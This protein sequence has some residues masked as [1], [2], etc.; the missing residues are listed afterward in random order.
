MS[1]EH[2][3]YLEG[4]KI[5]KLMI[6][7]LKIQIQLQIYNVFSCKLADR[8]AS[9]RSWNVLHV[10]SKKNYVLKPFSNYEDM[11]AGNFDYIIFI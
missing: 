5:Y 9:F 3:I 11:R 2:L 6:Q 4:N 8:I 10:I 1:S 7:E